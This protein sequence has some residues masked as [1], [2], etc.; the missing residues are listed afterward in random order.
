MTSLRAFFHR[1]LE[2]MFGPEVPDTHP[3]AGPVGVGPQGRPQVS[4]A[5]IAVVVFLTALGLLL[6][7]FALISAIYRD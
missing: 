4:A 3:W 1:L 5:G 7:A 2:A 6:G